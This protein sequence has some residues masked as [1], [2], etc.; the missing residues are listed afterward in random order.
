MEGACRTLLKINNN[1]TIITYRI[2]D[3]KDT[4]DKVNYKIR[5]VKCG[6]EEENA[7]CVQMKFYCFE[8][9]FDWD[10][11][12]YN[13]FY[14]GTMGPIIQKLVQKIKKREAKHIIVENNFFIKG[15]SERD[16]PPTQQHMWGSTKFLLI[17]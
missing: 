10:N 17:K 5:P 11:P 7:G 1:F 2:I 14:V 13:T 15:N 12:C 6:K 4:L 9:K 8:I 3:T 16:R